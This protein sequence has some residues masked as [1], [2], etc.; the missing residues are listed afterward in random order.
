MPDRVT[1]P[2]VSVL[3]VNY[4]YAHFIGHAI[5]S[6]LAQTYKNYEIVVCDDGSK[7]GSRAVIDRFA[8]ER[9]NVVKPVYKE[10]GGVASAL[11]EAFAASTGD[12]ICILDADDD[13]MPTKVASVVA[14]LGADPENG[15]AMNRMVKVN[16]DGK[17]AGMIPQVGRL[18]RGWIRNDLLRE[19]GHISFAPASG[20]SL[21]REAAEKVFPIP[22]D[23]FRT[24]ADAFI[25]TQ[26]LLRHKLA[27][28]DEPLSSYRLHGSN[29]TSSQDIDAAHTAKIMAGIEKVV[30]ALGDTAAELGLARPQIE[31]NP[32][33]AEQTLLNGYLS[34]KPRARLLGDAARLWRTAWRCRA[35]DRLRWRIKA[36]LLSVI[37]LLPHSVGAVVVNAIYL[38]GSPRKWFAHLSVRRRGG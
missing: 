2:L 38:P 12:I 17:I 13:F 21:T 9:P 24:E 32:T 14:A 28:L 37:L 22:E 18:D 4:N 25:L 3:I 5:Q 20:I 1:S 26:A 19:G 8:S 30:S 29:I 7:D 36:P 27:A 10:N 16:S 33:W 15:L 23:T 6:A 35:A 34:G 11:N 31:N